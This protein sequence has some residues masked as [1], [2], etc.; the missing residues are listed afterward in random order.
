[1]NNNVIIKKKYHYFFY[2]FI[3]KTF[4]GR[5]I[6]GRLKALEEAIR[7]INMCSL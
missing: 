6:K 3:R 1:M 5:I 4:D 7:K 2:S